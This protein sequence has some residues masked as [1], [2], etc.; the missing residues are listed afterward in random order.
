M[1]RAP[2]L[3]RDGPSVSGLIQVVPDPGGRALL[4]RLPLRGAQLPPRGSRRPLRGLAL[5]QPR[6]RGV[7][8]FPRDHARADALADP[9]PRRLGGPRQRPTLAGRRG[10]PGAEHRPRPALRRHRVA[11]RHVRP[12]RPR[13]NVQAEGTTEE[14]PR[15][16]S[17]TPFVPADQFHS[18]RIVE[19]AQR[20]LKSQRLKVHERRHRLLFA[21]PWPLRYILCRDIW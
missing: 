20:F 5:G 21:T 4:D 8:A 10:R 9:P 13:I 18:R 1:A 3:G 11:I 17:L 2:P 15:E 16:R 12:A 6:P 14:I 19:R 7:E